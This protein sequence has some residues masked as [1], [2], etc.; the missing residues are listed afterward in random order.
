MIGLLIRGMA[1]SSPD[2]GGRSTLPAKR[3]GI[4]AGLPEAH[5]ISE[6]RLVTLCH[7]EGRPFLALTVVWKLSYATEAGLLPIQREKSGL[8]TCGP[9]SVRS[10]RRG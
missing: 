9:S 7:S 6:A 8:T 2:S 1:F 10:G 3:D 5:F 4:H